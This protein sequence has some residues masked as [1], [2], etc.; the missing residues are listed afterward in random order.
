MR[1][2]CALLLSVLLLVGCRTDNSTMQLIERAEAVVIEYPDSALNILR[3]VDVET[4]RGE[5]D[6][7][8]YRLVLAET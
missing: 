5:E 6:M 1:L 3:T 8:H 4:I 2:L 7:A